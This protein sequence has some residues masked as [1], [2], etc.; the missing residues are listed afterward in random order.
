MTRW[1]IFDNY[2]RTYANPNS[3]EEMRK[4]VQ[5][6]TK[7]LDNI[8]AQLE[9]EYNAL[10]NQIN[11][12]LDAITGDSTMQIP[13]NFVADAIQIQRELQKKINIPQ[14]IPEDGVGPMPTVGQQRG[15]EVVEKAEE[16][17]FLR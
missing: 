8:K 4:L 16:I 3:K 12:M 7:G 1:K 17:D 2:I 15:Q 13:E 11:I 9:L 14:K 5:T 10:D 6:A